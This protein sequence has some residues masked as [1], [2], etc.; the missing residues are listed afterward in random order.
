[1]KA[2]SDTLTEMAPR[3]LSART[4][5][6]VPLELDRRCLF[7]EL[8]YHQR[9]PGAMSSRVWRQSFVVCRQPGMRVGRYPHVMLVWTA[10]AL[11]DVDETFGK[12]HAAASFRPPRNSNDLALLGPGVAISALDP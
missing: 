3:E 7:I 2:S 12:G 1:M 9:S 8:D 5:L 10:D 6:Q 11:Q 4:R